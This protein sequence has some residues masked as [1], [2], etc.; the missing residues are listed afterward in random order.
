M[1]L[2]LRGAA[3]RRNLV[4]RVLDTRSRAL[5]DFMRELCQQAYDTDWLQ[6]LEFALW[7]AVV[8]GP[9]TY[10]RL[11]ITAPHIAELRRLSD[12][13]GGWVYVDE[14]LGERMIPL[15]EWQDLFSRNIDIVQM[16]S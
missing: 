15:E 1:D 4:T 3:V 8:N 9:M 5:R 16:D 11:E 13:C 7:H 2:P 12:L 6:H 14:E 10:G